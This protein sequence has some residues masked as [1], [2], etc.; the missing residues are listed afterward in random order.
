[1]EHLVSKTW[2]L[3]STPFVCRSWIMDKI[4]LRFSKRG[5]T[6]Y[7]TVNEFGGE[8]VL[9]NVSSDCRSGT[10]TLSCITGTQ[11]GGEWNDDEVQKEAS[12]VDDFIHAFKEG[13]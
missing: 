4:R 9:S 10:I 1:M 12:A 3:V 11:M 6:L 7:D 8:F 2:V 13:T 5:A